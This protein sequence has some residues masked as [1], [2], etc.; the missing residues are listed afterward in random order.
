MSS[1]VASPAPAESAVAD[2][3]GTPAGAPSLSEALEGNASGPSALTAENQPY[4]QMLQEF[5][6]SSGVNA[7]EAEAS[8]ALAESEGQD[9]GASPAAE[10]GVT[11]SSPPVAPAAPQLDPN[12]QAMMT[13][14]QSVQADS[15][16]REQ[17]LLAQIEALKP[18]ALEAPPVDPFANLPDKFNT[19]EIKEF[20]QVAQEK[21]LAPYKNEMEG[22]IQKAQ[23]DRQ[24]NFLVT[25]ATSTAEA[26]VSAGYDLQGED[27]A[28]VKDGLRDFALV[29][30]DKYG[31]TPAQYKGA[32]T[33][34]ADSLVRGRQ[35]HMNKAAKAKVATMARP[36]AKPNAAS[37][38]VPGQQPADYSWAEAR[39]AGYQDMTDAVFDDGRKVLAM[40]ARNQG[41]G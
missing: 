36:V 22:R 19:P 41:R 33:K 4:E 13:L 16:R 37:G 40:R 5:S 29:L 11:A 38:V 9:T 17:L 14:I 26:I 15:A 24:V 3:S 35:A 21:I 20:L 10:P 34:I 27:A 39:A 18:K 1:F 8:R 2:P 30:T 6:D 28:I 12:T 25:D 23:F 7:I 32:L 31:G